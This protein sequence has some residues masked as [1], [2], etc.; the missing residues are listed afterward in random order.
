MSNAQ[1]TDPIKDLITRWATAEGLQLRGYI[2]KPECGDKDVREC[3]KYRLKDDASSRAIFVEMVNATE[4]RYKA[5]NK[6]Q[7]LDIAEP[8]FYYEADPNDPSAFFLRA[9][10]VEFYEYTLLTPILASGAS[11]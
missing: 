3:P 8:C 10:L 1:A 4:A 6:H 2:I 11:Q 9:V 5:V 7:H